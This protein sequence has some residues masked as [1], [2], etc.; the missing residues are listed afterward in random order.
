MKTTNFIVPLCFS[1]LLFHCS[2]SPTESETKPFVTTLWVLESFNIS[3]KII[4]PPEDQVYNIQFKNDSTFSGR[5]DCNDIH[6]SYITKQNGVIYINARGTTFIYCG[7]QSKDKDY[8]SAINQVFS[9]EVNK[10]QLLLRYGEDSV[11]T[12]IGK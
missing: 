11:L 3:G 10:N 8:Y 5:N 7:D 4:K 6:G 2:N 9:Y 1:L 12:F